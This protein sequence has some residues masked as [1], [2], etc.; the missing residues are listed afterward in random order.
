MTNR[1]ILHI[2]TEKTGSTS[3]Q[4]GIR[5]NKCLLKDNNIY[6]V[7]PTPSFFMGPGEKLKSIRNA[8]RQFPRKS[9]VLI[10]SELFQSRLKTEQELVTLK[11]ALLKT[12]P[13]RKDIIVIVYLR[14]QA[15]IANSM[16]STAAMYGDDF[17]QSPLSPYVRTICNHQRTLRIWSNVFG[18]EQVKP[19]LFE[20]SNS[21]IDF[22]RDFISTFCAAPKELVEPALK[23][24]GLSHDGILIARAV[25]N[26]IKCLVKEGRVSADLARESGAQIVKEKV[27]KIDQGSKFMLHP[28]VWKLFD[29][30]YKQM[31]KNLKNLYFPE[32]SQE[33]LFDLNIRHDSPSEPSITESYAEDQAIKLAEEY[34]AEQV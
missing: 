17:K 7:L 16:V 18:E 25:H 9:D 21:N 28:A 23:N 24:P 19:K 15:A 32:V 2:G 22:F 5:Q 33:F 14:R 8:S 30:E 20:P 13:Q 31:N 6:P 10:S 29:N 12:F 4:A 1:I 34:L 27:A 11:K 3:I 26:Y